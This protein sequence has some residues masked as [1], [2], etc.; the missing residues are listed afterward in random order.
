MEQQNKLFDKYVSK[1]INSRINIL[2]EKFIPFIEGD[3]FI[4]NF[5]E[6]SG[7][8]KREDYGELIGVTGD[9]VAVLD[10]SAVGKDLEFYELQKHYS[11]KD[12]TLRFSLEFTKFEDLFKPWSL[13]DNRHLNNFLEEFQINGE[14]YDP[15]LLIGWTYFKENCVYDTSD[16]KDIIYIRPDKKEYEST[17]YINKECKV[18]LLGNNDKNKYNLPELFNLLCLL[19]LNIYGLRTETV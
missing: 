19:K 18:F 1:Y 2:V 4:Q 7:T 13:D 10:T 11:L 16:K 15:I 14:T 12:N 6:G 3:G 8:W 9:S 17:L 5:E